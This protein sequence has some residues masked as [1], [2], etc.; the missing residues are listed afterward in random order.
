MSKIRIQSTGFVKHKFVKLAYCFEQTDVLSKSTKTA[1]KTNT[2]D[3]A[4]CNG[5]QDGGVKEH[6]KHISHLLLLD[7]NTDPQAKD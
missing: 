2:E 6:I 4:A 7:V 5:H 1:K 3:D